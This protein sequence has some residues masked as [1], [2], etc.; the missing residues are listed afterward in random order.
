MRKIWN[1]L[2]FSWKIPLFKKIFSCMLEF[3][4][5]FFSTYIKGAEL[6]NLLHGAGTKCLRAN[7]NVIEFGVHELL[8]FPWK[9]VEMPVQRIDVIKWNNAENKFND[10]AGKKTERS[11]FILSTLSTSATFP[12]LNKKANK[13][14]LKRLTNCCRS[15]CFQ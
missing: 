5:G 8:I 3:L 14:I 4:F 2:K 11:Y 9:Y 13:K 12:R 10:F 1:Y 15:Q 7:N 6:R